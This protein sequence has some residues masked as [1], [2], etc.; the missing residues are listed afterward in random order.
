VLEFLKISDEHVA[1]MMNMMHHKH[2]FND[3]IIKIM[4]IWQ[5]HIKTHGFNMI[6]HENVSKT[7]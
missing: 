6:S 7:P 1:N 3:N 4:K 5:K 2:T